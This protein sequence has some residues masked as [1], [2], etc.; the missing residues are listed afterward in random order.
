MLYTDYQWCVDLLQKGIEATKYSFNDPTKT[1]LVMIKL[2]K[3]CT[4]ISY[5]NKVQ[6]KDFFGRYFRLP[7]SFKIDGIKG[8]TFGPLSFTF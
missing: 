8:F 5:S 4:S 2:N 7:R 3:K 6:A 1:K